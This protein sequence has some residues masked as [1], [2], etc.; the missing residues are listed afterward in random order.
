MKKFSLILV[1]LTIVVLT[2][3][4]VAAASTTASVNRRNRGFVHGIVI[5]VDSR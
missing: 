2:V 5:P 1:A 4:M 3:P